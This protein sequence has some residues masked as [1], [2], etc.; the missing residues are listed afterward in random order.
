MILLLLLFL[1]IIF[2]RASR[3]KFGWRPFLDG[4]VF[5]TQF[6]RRGLEGTHVSV[7]PL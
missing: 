7:L 6:A 2:L 5:N 4:K 3:H 1:W